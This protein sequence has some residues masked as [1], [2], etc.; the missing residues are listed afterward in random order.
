MSIGP[1]QQ[2]T[3]NKRDERLRTM[4][5][6]MVTESGKMIPYDRALEEA[7]MIYCWIKKGK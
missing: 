6:R 5:L 1:S 3:D 4:C 7:K 2:E